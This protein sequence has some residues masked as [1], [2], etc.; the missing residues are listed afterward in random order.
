MAGKMMNLVILALLPITL[1]MK[2]NGASGSPSETQAPHKM[3]LSAVKVTANT[4]SELG[5]VA[6]RS[7]EVHRNSMDEISKTMTGIR[8]SLIE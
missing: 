2:I 6:D 1:S 3:M 4:I 7:M 8:I 5:K